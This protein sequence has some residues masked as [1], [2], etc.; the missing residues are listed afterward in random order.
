[1]G[2]DVQRVVVMNHA[3]LPV[4]RLGEHGMLVLNRVGASLRSFRGATENIA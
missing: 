3:L 4:N 1:V 2:F